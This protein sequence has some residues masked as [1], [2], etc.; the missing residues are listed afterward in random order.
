MTRWTDEQTRTDNTK[1]KLYAFRSLRG[2]GIYNKEI[3]KFD[4]LTEDLNNM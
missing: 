3:I 2:R 1:T 4:I